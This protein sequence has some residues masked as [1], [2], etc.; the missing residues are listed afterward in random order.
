MPQF[1]PFL[2]F[3]LQNSNLC[4]STPVPVAQ[5]GHGASIPS[6][7]HGS[8]CFG[9]LVDGS[10]LEERLVWLNKQTASLLFTMASSVCVHVCACTC[11][12]PSC[13]PLQTS[14]TWPGEAYTISLLCRCTSYQH[15]CQDGTFKLKFSLFC[16]TIKLGMGSWR[17][18]PGYIWSA[19]PYTSWSIMRRHLVE[20][21][22]VY[23]AMHSRQLPC[24]ALTS[25][26]WLC[27]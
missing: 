27:E 17:E 18:V 19:H 21:I 9:K 1:L 3:F 10:D 8:E 14:L 15:I 24:Q 7:A 5:Q 26:S 13:P 4:S 12:I 2:F 16:S 23:N 22:F 6:R 11:V 20:F 25:T